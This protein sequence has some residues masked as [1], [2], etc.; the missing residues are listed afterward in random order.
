M[1]LVFVLVNAGFFPVHP[2]FCPE[3]RK[4]GAGA[5]IG[6]AAGR[7]G[8]RSVNKPTDLRVGFGLPGLDLD[9]EMDFER[10][11]VDRLA[12]FRILD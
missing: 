5:L 12:G 11:L 1:A 8:D 10:L 2:H 4:R 7:P 3:H 9:P 6:D